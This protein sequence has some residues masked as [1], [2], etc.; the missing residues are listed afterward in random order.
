[1]GPVALNLLAV[2]ASLVPLR[3]DR[4]PQPGRGSIADFYV[5]GRRVHPVAQRHEATAADWMSAASFLSMA[6]LTPGRAM[7]PELSDGLDR[8][9]CVAGHAVA[10]ICASP[11]R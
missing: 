5:A 10:P 9:L 7:A 4:G 6:G 8:G 1:M 11:A 3:A 2:G